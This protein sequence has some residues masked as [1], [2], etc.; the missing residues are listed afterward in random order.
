MT[1][2]V[3]RLL[4]VVVLLAGC[5]SAA[6]NPVSTTPSAGPG[7]SAAAPAAASSAATGPGA[8]PTSTAGANPSAPVGSPSA[9]PS[10]PTG[11]SAPPPRSPSAKPEALP[12]TGADSYEHIFVVVFENKGYDQ[13]VGSRAAPN[14]NRLIAAGALATASHAIRHPSLPNYLALIGG[15][16]FGI[17]TDCS[18]ASCPVNATNLGSLLTGHGRTW[19]AYMESMPAAC[20]TKTAGLYAAKHNPFVYFTNIRTTALCRSVVPYSRLATDLKRSATTPRFA[21]VTPDLCHDMHDCSVATGDRWLGTFAD[22][23]MASPAWTADRS[24]L[25]VTF[26]EDDRSSGNRIVTFAIGSPVRRSVT[27]GARS[28]VPSDHYSLLRTLEHYLGVPTLGRNDAE[29]AVMT[30][31]IPG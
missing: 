11:G 12:A 13:I 6:S 19:K 1:R 28:S 18:P 7:S 31:L 4:A 25:I 15:S 5:D 29:R 17:T 8:G 30:D 14:F 21:F 2:V 27:P 26:D 23:V 9:V 20:E 10:P 3:A 24:L 22:A 16:T